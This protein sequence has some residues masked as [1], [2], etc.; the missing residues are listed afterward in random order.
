[1]TEHPDAVLE[2]AMRRAL[3]L[4]EQGPADNDNPQVGCVLVAPDGSFVAEGWHRGAGTPHAEVD[5]LAN[6]TDTWRARTGE[7]TAVV[8]LEPCN[9][10]G[11]TGP[12]AVAL[13]D[14]G[15][16]GVVYALPDPGDA[17]S[18]GA[19]RLSEAGVAVRSGVLAADAKALLNSW[20]QRHAAQQP[21]SRP[22]ITVKWGQSLDG[23]IA[24]A[25]GSSQWITSVA[26][27]RDVH[28]R[29]AAADGILVGTGTL[30]ADDPA[31]TARAADGSLLAAQPRPIVMGER[32]IPPGARIREHPA[33]EAGAVPLQISGRELEAELA[34]L[35]ESGIQ[36]IFVEG[37][38][39]VI[40]AF[41]R[42][43][44]VDELLV[45]VAPLLLGGPRLAIDDLG[46]ASLA[47]G[48]RL[49]VTERTRFEHDTL[50]VARPV[51][52]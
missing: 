24:A 15:I 35:L 51:R 46:V 36:S 13:L 37:G 41:L 25:D 29:R 16:G 38:A 52:P 8:T 48:L 23:R 17:S 2:Q 44:L 1:M 28:Q 31:L 43:G 7:L 50:V 18:G 21:R 45:Y 10:H 26:S 6:L 33:L 47:Q 19:L 32:A 42:E 5:A 3:E 27:R 49:N 12:C 4:A 14:A 40:S 34:R 22:R 11:R 39:S 30:I 20:L 9:H